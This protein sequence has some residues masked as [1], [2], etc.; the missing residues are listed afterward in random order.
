LLAVIDRG[1]QKKPGGTGSSNGI[2]TRSSNGVGTRKD[3]KAE[4][5]NNFLNT[6]S[7]DE[8]THLK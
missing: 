2:G 8:I 4:Y 1:K 5:T 3:W 6:L 7:D